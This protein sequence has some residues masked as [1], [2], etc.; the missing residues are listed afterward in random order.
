MSTVQ[1]TDKVLVQRATTLHSA[2]ADMSTVQDTDLILVNRA[3]VDYHCTFADWK[4][5]QRK[6]PVIAS[7]TLA[8]SPEAG[9]F[10]SG[11]FRSTVVMADDGTPASTKGVKAYVQGALK[12]ATTTANVTATATKTIDRA[13]K[14][15]IVLGNGAAVVWGSPAGFYS[16][17]TL[18]YGGAIYQSNSTVKFN[19]AH[20]DFVGTVQFHFLDSSTTAWRNGFVIATFSGGGTQ[21]FTPTPDTSLAPLHRWSG[22]VTVPA[23]E[24]IVSLSGSAVGTTGAW[25]QL[26]VCAVFVNASGGAIPGNGTVQFIDA[27]FP[28]LTFADATG[29]SSLAAGDTITQPSSGATGVISSIDVATLTILLTGVTGTWAIGSPARGPLKALPG[30][31]SAK[32]YCTLNAG[33][34]VT[35]LQSADPGFTAVTGAGPYTVTFPATLPSGNPPDTDL[36]AGTS[37]TTEVQASNSKAT[38]SKVSNTIVPS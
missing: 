7:V 30:G 24:H 8:D 34:T 15:T 25:G 12:T 26:L 28:S 1:P 21:S 2:P 6:P 14:T 18:N 3:G 27:S 16:N 17:G 23:G 35:D 4:A 5:S 36:P 31:A 32:L 9:R 10:T 19:F 20:T 33:L 22:T 29:L 37:L 11:A 38:V 13:S